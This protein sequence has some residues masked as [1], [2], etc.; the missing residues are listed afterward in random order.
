MSIGAGAEWDNSIVPGVDR[1]LFGLCGAGHQRPSQ[2]SP[3]FIC[4]RAHGK[5]VRHPG[6]TNDL[7]KGE[8]IPITVFA[9]VSSDPRVSRQPICRVFI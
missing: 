6:G 1:K 5:P 9:T 2:N 3:R 8:I 7:F 4:G